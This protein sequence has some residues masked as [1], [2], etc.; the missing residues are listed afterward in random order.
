QT[1]LIRFLHDL[2]VVLNFNDEDNPYKLKDTTILNPEWVTDGV[3][4]II[5]DNRLVQGRGVLTRQHLNR[6][7]PD[8]TYPADKKDV[9]VEMMRRFELCFEFPEAK[10]ERWLVPELLLKDEPALDW[11]ERESLN[12]QYH[13]DVLPGGLICRFI[14]R[15]HTYI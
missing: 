6:I 15:M 12:F 9:I 5:N 14:V 1:T 10:G 7:L 11:R 8:D 3:Y 13:Y 4:A 2:G